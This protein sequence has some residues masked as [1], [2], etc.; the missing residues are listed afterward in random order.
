MNSTNSDVYAIGSLARLREREWVAL[1]SDNPDVLSLKPLSGS[2]AEARRA[3]S[4]QRPSPAR[5]A[6]EKKALKVGSIGEIT[7]DPDNPLAAVTPPGIQAVPRT[8][9][10]MFLVNTSGHSVSVQS[11]RTVSDRVA[12]KKLRGKTPMQGYEVL[13]VE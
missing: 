4:P 7:P 6:R 9:G 11:G 8:D 13:W 10:S 2:E 12:G 5:R 3:A 1:P